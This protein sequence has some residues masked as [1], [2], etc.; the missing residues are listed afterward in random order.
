MTLD[1]ILASQSVWFAI[2]AFA[3]VWWLVLS[4]MARVSGWNALEEAYGTGAEI[5]GP[6]KRFQSIRMGHGAMQV[7]SFGSI[8]N[9]TVSFSG[10]QVETFFPFNL[11]MKRFVV[12]WPDVTAK[13][14]LAL[15]GFKFVE[16]RFARAPTI[17]MQL[18]EPTLKWIEQNAGVSIPRLPA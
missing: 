5:D 14:V 17:G 11:T 9:F 3:F 6:K 7:A 18:G 12:P 2:A 1:D 15:L 13:P 4:I 16:L 8:I 10:L